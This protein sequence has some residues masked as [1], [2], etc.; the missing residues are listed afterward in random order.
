MI[1]K[2]N[3]DKTILTPPH[4]TTEK[5]GLEMRRVQS[6]LF[7]VAGRNATNGN[8]LIFGQVSRET[9]RG[10]RAHRPKKGVND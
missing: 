6:T 8:N 5:G 1:V 3:G 2:V 10:R 7:D 4:S 9:V